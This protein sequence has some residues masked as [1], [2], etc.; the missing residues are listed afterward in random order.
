MAATLMRVDRDDAGNVEV[1]P[2]RPR[3]LKPLDADEDGGD[4]SPPVKSALKKPA[5]KS[6]SRLDKTPTPPVQE[7]ETKPKSALKSALKGGGKSKTDSCEE[8]PASPPSMKSALRQEPRPP[9]GPSPKKSALKSRPPPPTEP[10]PSAKSASESAEDLY[11][12][13]PKGLCKRYFMFA[14][15]KALWDQTQSEKGQQRKMIRLSDVQAHLQNPVSPSSTHARMSFQSGRHSQSLI[16]VDDLAKISEAN[17]EYEI[18]PLKVL[19]LEKKLDIARIRSLLN[20]LTDREKWINVTLDA[21]PPAMPPPLFHAVAGVHVNLV[22]LL[23]EFRVNVNVEYQ[24]T[25]MLKGWIK[26]KTPLLECVRNRKGRFVGTMLGEKLASIEDLLITASEAAPLAP[27]SPVSECASELPT[28]VS[29]TMRQHRK[30]FQMKCSS[31]HMLHTHGHPNVKYDLTS[32]FNA[33]NQCS[34]REAISQETGQGYAIKAGKKLL[35][36]SGKDQESELWNEILILRKADHPNV[37]KLYETLEDETHIFLVLELCQGG[38]LFDHIVRLGFIPEKTCMRLTYQMGSAIRHL[39]QHRICHRDIQPESFLINAE[40]S[41]MEASVKLCDFDRAKEMDSAPMTTKCF[42]LHY[43]APEIITS[44][45]GYGAKIDVWSLG[46]LIYVMVSGMPPFDAE[47]EVDVL[48][49]IQSGSY[50]FSPESIWH[51]ISK[52]TTDIIKACVIVNP[53]ERLDIW[54]LMELKGIQQAEEDG[55][56]YTGLRSNSPQE[57]GD[58]AQKILRSVFSIMAESLNDDQINNLRRMFRRL[59]SCERGMVEISECKDELRNMLQEEFVNNDELFGLIDNES[60]AGK[61][62]YSLFLANMTDRRRHIRRDAAR[63]IFDSFDIDKNGL[64]SLYELAQALE[65]E[66]LRSLNNP[67]S[68]PSDVEIKAIWQEMKAAFGGQNLQDK[69]FT[70]EEFFKQLP[71]AHLELTI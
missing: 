47:E 25:S 71:K 22:E 20:D 15:Q 54:S 5:L 13:T 24:G 16:L 31:G 62:N 63:M 66:E 28:P 61:V 12:W 49:A 2:Q 35:E 65:M 64:V 4:A 18:S 30:S 45:S 41:L 50:S 58:N 9:P 36:A 55:A 33:L 57:K 1:S 48:R 56:L 68:S 43:V 3:K 11:Q 37:V 40:G 32:K 53:D 27:P 21:T 42:T 14:A 59:D 8:P 69:E 10:T 67:K 46:V 29:D 7:V 51:G 39:H 17:N 70:F 60:F 44:S 19:L 38:L 52:E 6:V 34:V 23:V 26:P